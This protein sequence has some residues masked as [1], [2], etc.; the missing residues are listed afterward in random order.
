VIPI[1]RNSPALGVIAISALIADETEKL[2]E[3]EFFGV[4]NPSKA[5]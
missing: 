3:V 2:D 5:G 1:N 4:R